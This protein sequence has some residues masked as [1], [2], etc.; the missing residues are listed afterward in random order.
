VS[1]KATFEVWVNPTK[2]TP[3]GYVIFKKSTFAI[4]L[5]DQE[6]RCRACRKLTFDAVILYTTVG[7]WRRSRG[8]FLRAIEFSQLV[9]AFGNSQPGWKWIHSDWRAPFDEWSHVAV[10]YDDEAGVSCVYINGMR[11]RSGDE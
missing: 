6:V 4:A 2:S 10:T 3:L 8:N 11:V 9:V 5:Q 1:G 7:C